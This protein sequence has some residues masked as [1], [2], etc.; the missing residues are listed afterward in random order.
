[1][2]VATKIDP[3]GVYDDLGVYDALEI[4]TSALARARR[5]GGLRYVRRGGRFLYLG[6]W[7]L[8]WLTSNPSAPAHGGGDAGGPGLPAAKKGRG[9]GRQRR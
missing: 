3:D 1:M 8:S 4:R 9:R 5:D 6:S 2:A 7:L